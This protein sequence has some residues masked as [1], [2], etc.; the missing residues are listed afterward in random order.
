MVQKESR[1]KKN[2]RISYQIYGID[3]NC[4]RAFKSQFT[5]ALHSPIGY[6]CLYNELIKAL[7]ISLVKSFNF[8]HYGHQPC[9]CYNVTYT[10]QMFILSHTRSISCVDLFIHI[11]EWRVSYEVTCIS[12]KPNQIESYEVNDY[13]LHLLPSRRSGQNIMV[14]FKYRKIHLIIFINKQ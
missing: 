7:L 12:S 1:R 11:Q 13:S 9:F 5:D 6:Y 4:W 3:I 14:P 8:F 2:K 10:V